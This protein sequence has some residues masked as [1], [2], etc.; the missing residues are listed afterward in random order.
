MVIF[1]WVFSPFCITTTKWALSSYLWWGNQ[2]GTLTDIFS[3][4]FLNISDIP[5]QVMP[6]KTAFPPQISKLSSCPWVNDSWFVVVWKDTWSSSNLSLAANQ[7]Q[8][9]HWR[10]TPW[11]FTKRRFLTCGRPLNAAGFPMFSFWS[12]GKDLNSAIRA[13]IMCCSNSGVSI[14]IDSIWNHKNVIQ[15]QFT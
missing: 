11:R 2:F 4:R 12:R 13:S 7:P 8:S 1:L 3:C 9:S 15:V 6:M 5:K 10:G 14:S